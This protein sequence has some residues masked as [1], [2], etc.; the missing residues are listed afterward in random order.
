MLVRKCDENVAFDNL[1]NLFVPLSVGEPET[2]RSPMLL[3]GEAP[4]C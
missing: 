4:S 3:R 2:F 1:V